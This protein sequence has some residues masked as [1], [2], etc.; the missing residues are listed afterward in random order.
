MR[1]LLVANRGEIAIRVIRAAR[2]L[3][4]PTVASLSTANAVRLPSTP[5]LTSAYCFMIS[6]IPIVWSA[7]TGDPTSTNG[8]SVGDGLR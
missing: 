1:K 7:V 8:G 6:T 2:E 3:G 4:I 5:A